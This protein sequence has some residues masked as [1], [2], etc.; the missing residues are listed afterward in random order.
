[1]SGGGLLP[2]G[3]GEESGISEISTYSDNTDT[4]VHV[5]VHFDRRIQGIRVNVYGRSTLWYFER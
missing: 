2:L 1:M 5:I 4:F 3:G